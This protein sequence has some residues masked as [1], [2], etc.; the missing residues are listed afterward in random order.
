MGKTTIQWTDVSWNPVRGC[1]RVSPGCGGPG[2][3]GGCYAEIMAARFSGIHPKT[4]KP[5]W[6][7]GFA[8]M[9]GGDHRWTGKVELVP[10]MLTYP[11]RLRKA[12]RIFVNSTSDLFHEKLPFEAIDRVFAHMAMCP[13]H[14]FQILTKR[15][16]RMRAYMTDPETER[17]VGA[18]MYEDAPWESESVGFHFKEIAPLGR[19]GDGIIGVSPW[20]LPNVWHGTSVEDQERA[21]ERI[22]HLLQ[23][24]AAVRF[25]SAEPLLGPIDLSGFVRKALPG[26]RREWNTYVWPSWVPSDVRDQIQ[27][28]W[29]PDWGRG[30][31]TW[32]RGAIENGQPPIGTD[33]EYRLCT[34]KEHRVA[35]RFIPAWNNIGRVLDR[36][37][38][39]HT[40]SAG[41][42][43][44]KPPFLDWVIVGGESG[45]G[46]RPMHPDWAR[47]LRAQCAASGT[48]YFFKQ[49]G[50]WHP[51]DHAIVGDT[52]HTR[53][54]KDKAG[55]LLDGR[56]WDEFPPAPVFTTF[57]AKAPA[58]GA[59]WDLIS[60]APT[61]RRIEVCEMLAGEP[62]RIVEVVGVVRWTWAT[63]WREVRSV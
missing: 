11:L 30:P 13:R 33:G 46:A 36:A 27:K 35:G 10:S 61:D 49:W 15:P 21:D 37:G 29:N 24:P 59:D 45:P 9:K 43:A 23:T 55:R 28:F 2:P 57:A 53:V 1:S 51:N 26:H 56:E 42:G 6:G 41:K 38:N 12:S 16:E 40:V 58:L 8:E 25:I 14:T 60:T 5:M 7:H 3:V 20:P 22:P 18:R 54:G 44:S 62:Q 34:A 4:G 52:G 50:E 31:D 48:Y 39:I 32:M 63:H 47:S 17:R 19:T